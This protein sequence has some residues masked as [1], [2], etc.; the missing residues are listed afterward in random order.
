[1]RLFVVQLSKNGSLSALEDT[2][3]IEQHALFIS[4]CI[5]KQRF[6]HQANLTTI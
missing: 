6:F 4:C 1:M 5:H 2:D 3:L